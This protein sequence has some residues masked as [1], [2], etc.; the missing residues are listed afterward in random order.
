[1]GQAFTSWRFVAAM[2]IFVA[3]AGVPPRLGMADEPAPQVVEKSMHEFMEYV[4]QPAYKRLQPAMAAAPADAAGWK[5]VKGESLVMAEAANLLLDRAPAAEGADGADADDW[6]ALAVEVRTHGGELY[7]AAKK[8]DYA[9]ARTAYE[10]MLKSCNECHTQFHKGK[11][12]L[13]L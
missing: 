13:A 5:I 4:Y 10:T 2:G 3:A 8:K 1:M 9:A 7:A 11:P 6:K 12:Q